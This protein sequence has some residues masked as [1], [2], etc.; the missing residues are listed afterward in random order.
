MSNVNDCPCMECLL[1]NICYKSCKKF[2]DKYE[3]MMG[4]K[5]SIYKGW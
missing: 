3:E 1:K 2:S 4:F 5:P